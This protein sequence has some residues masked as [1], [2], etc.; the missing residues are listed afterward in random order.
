MGGS[1][2][3]SPFRQAA[4]SISAQGVNL[5]AAEASRE[6]LKSRLSPVVDEVT[7]VLVEAFVTQVVFFFVIVL[8]VVVIAVAVCANV[9]GLNAWEVAAI[10]SV[11]LVVVIVLL[12]VISYSALDAGRQTVDTIV[13]G[14]VDTFTPN[15]IESALNAGANSYLQ[16]ILTQC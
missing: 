2:P 7:Q 9:L 6:Y 13:Q 12:V 8:I 16:A 4:I 1:C 15:V 11:F 5:Q 3:S 10:V 14:T